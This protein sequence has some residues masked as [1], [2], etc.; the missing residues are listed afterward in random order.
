[1]IVGLLDIKLK[2]Q[3]QFLCNVTNVHNVMCLWSITAGRWVAYSPRLASSQVH[4]WQ[5]TTTVGRQ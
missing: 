2:G 4:L 1:M 5:V 3:L